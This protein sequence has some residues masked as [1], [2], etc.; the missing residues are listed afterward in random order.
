MAEYVRCGECKSY[1]FHIWVI[2]KAYQGSN[3][4]LKNVESLLQI[5]KRLL[6]TLGQEEFKAMK[7]GN[8]LQRR[9]G[10]FGNEWV[11]YC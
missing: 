5:R 1:Q 6:R 3:H 8:N 7:K 10:A 2:L 9:K 11:L 4:L